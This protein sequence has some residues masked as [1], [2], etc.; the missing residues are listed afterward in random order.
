MRGNCQGHS[1]WCAQEKESKHNLANASLFRMTIEWGSWASD[2][3]GAT[4]DYHRATRHVKLTKWIILFFGSFGSALML[5]CAVIT[6]PLVTPAV[7][8]TASC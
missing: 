2:F 6:Q 3:S 7:Y 5:A 4:D 8:D 1:N